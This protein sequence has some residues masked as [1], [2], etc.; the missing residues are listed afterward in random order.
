MK[1]NTDM[2]VVTKARSNKLRLR[3]NLDGWLFLSVSL[4]GYLLFRFIP[5]V[6]SL[7]LSFCD[8]NLISGLKGIRFVGLDNFAELLHDQWFISSLMN[9]FYF[10]FVSV[11]ISIGLS[12]LVAVIVNQSVYGK[13]LIRL[14]LYSPHISSMVA[15]SVIWAILYS[16]SFGPINM[17]LKSI[18]ISNPP[19]WISSSTWAMP[20]LIIM[21]I[22]QSIGY[23]MVIMLAGLQGIP[24]DYYEAAEVDGAN[25]FQKFKIITIPLM[26]PTLFFV[27]ITSVIGS[28]QI[29]AQV[30]I[31]TQGGPG[32]STSVL[33]Y[34]I[35]NV[36]FNYN[37]MG[38]ANSIAWVLFVI[39]LVLTLW[40]WRQ[41]K[42]WVHTQ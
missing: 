36:A 33:V 40:Q 27:M 18:G 26:S 1:P 41:Q 35:Y 15:I 14:L 20:S 13:G 42:K 5:I 9:T 32:T 23:N 22:W 11:P 28:F 6:F 17:F 39:I 21:S 37:R 8:W 12:L 2:I 34:Y 19:G 24:K 25:L 4:V 29:F 16:P 30:N 10:A 31:M 38:Y 3:E 7:V